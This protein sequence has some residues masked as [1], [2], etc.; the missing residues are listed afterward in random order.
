[1]VYIPPKH[2]SPLKIVHTDGIL[3]LLICEGTPLPSNAFL[4][5]QWGGIMI[6]NLNSTAPKS[7]Q[8]SVKE[9]HP[10]I[11]TFAEQLRNLLGVVPTRFHNRDVLLVKLF[12]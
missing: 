6:Q 4:I 3:I 1:M 11:E 7:V 8:L 9:M 2:T 10:I 12:H 5:P